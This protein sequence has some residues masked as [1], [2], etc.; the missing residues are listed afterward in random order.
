M[1]IR[2]TVG[3]AQNVV[4]PHRLGTATGAL[5]F[6]RSL[7]GAIIV[8]TFGAIVLG[9][10]DGPAQLLQHGKLVAGTNADAA[11]LAA[12]FRWVF[13]AGAAV[14]WMRDG[15]RLIKSSS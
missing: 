5:N 15:L 3:G 13:V 10:V 8:A 6:F 12:A 14:Q 11:H 2:H 9:A 4:T 7:G 1:S